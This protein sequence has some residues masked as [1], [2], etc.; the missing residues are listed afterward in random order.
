[1]KISYTRTVYGTG[2]DTVTFDNVEPAIAEYAEQF[3]V[4]EVVEVL[5]ELGYKPKYATTMTID[6]V[7]G[8]ERI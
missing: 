4:Y 2:H 5:E 7:D 6:D 8:W 1:M 3:G